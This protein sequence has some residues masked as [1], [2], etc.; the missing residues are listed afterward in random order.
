M[1]MA[2][3]NFSVIAVKPVIHVSWLPRLLGGTKQNQKRATMES[4]G[5]SF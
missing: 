2:V 3:L 4:K 5:L 1:Y